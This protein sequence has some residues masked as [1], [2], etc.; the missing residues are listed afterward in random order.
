MKITLIAPLPPLKFISPYCDDLVNA[1]YKK[2][3]IEVIGYQQILPNYMYCGEPIEKKNTTLPKIKNIKIFN[4]IK[5]FNPFSWIK[6]AMKVTT[7]IVHIQ[8]WT[9]YANFAFF[10]I[11]PILKI[12]KKIIVITI[13]NITPHVPEKSVILI[14]RIF[15]KILFL[16]GDVFIVHNKRNK[17]KLLKLYKIDKNKIHIITMG[18]NSYEKKNISKKDARKKL[19]IPQD[20][21]VLLFFGYIWR[22]KGLDTLLKAL[23]LIKKKIPEILLIIAGQP[24]NKKDSWDRYDI[25][26]KEY[27]L[28]DFIIKRLEYI[29]KLEIPLYFSATDIVV[30]SYKEPFDTHGAVGSLSLSFKK[31]LVVTDIGGLPEYVK[32]KNAISPPEDFQSLA[33]N[34][35]RIFKDYKL[36]KKLTVDAKNRA[37]ELSWDTIVEKNIEL[38]KSLIKN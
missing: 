36:F 9:Y 13:H 15:N 18:V 10:I 8:H 4:I 25:L 21:K 37:I 22:Y 7:K 31:P 5:Y 20:K 35:I 2:V 19:K 34:I 11:L 29:P 23:V 17:E 26:I 24:L 12:R 32:D 38:Y 1:L 28:Q 6:A 30:L 3:D 16:F 33:N 27:N 14:D